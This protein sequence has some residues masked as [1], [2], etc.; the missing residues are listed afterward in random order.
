M[1]E[2]TVAPTESPVMQS[3]I[4]WLQQRLENAEKKIRILI[5]M[6]VSQ[7]VLT[8][9]LAKVFSE[10]KGDK[11]DNTAVLKWYL[12]KNRKSS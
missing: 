2:K 12:D 5:D 1:D 11:G 7:K 9:E 3:D 4:R 6:L 8:P 10:T